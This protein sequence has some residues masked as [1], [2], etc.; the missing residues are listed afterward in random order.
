MN[1]ELQNFAREYLKT[2]LVTLPEKNQRM[3][4]SMYGRLDGKRSLEEAHEMPIEAIVDEIPDNELDWAMTQT[5]NTLD[6][7]MEGEPK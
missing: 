6:G 5:S 1:P 3:F 2:T 4:K 7:L